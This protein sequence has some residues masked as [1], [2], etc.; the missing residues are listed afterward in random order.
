[1]EHDARHGI[2]DSA[3][4]FAETMLSDVLHKVVH[5]AIDRLPEII[6]CQLRVVKDEAREELRL[7]GAK[8]IQVAGLLGFGAVFAIFGV[9]FLLM[10]ITYGLAMA[11]PMWSAALVVAVG[12]AMA[13]MV[14]L[15]LGKKRLEA[16]S[17]HR[18]IETVGGEIAGDLVRCA[19]RSHTRPGSVS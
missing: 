12:T 7:A 5:D 6:V 9:G 18:P 2:L 10:A 17:A 8:M 15:A 1:M 11:I 13:A 16:P 19:D 4:R 14:L 3:Q